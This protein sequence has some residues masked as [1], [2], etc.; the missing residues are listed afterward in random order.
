MTKTL[1]D[2]EVEK[3][4]MEKGIEQGEEKK[5]IEIAKIAIKKGLSDELISELTEL[6][7]EKIS[8]IRYSI[9]H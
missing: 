3:R 7:C 9:S 1:Y 6:S 4:G 5:S 8:I 2:P